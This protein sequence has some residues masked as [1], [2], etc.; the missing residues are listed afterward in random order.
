MLL[1][2]LPNCQG[3]KIYFSSDI[4]TSWLVD[5]LI[6]QLIIVFNSSFL[7][8]LYLIPYRIENDITVILAYVDAKPK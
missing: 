4:M 7:L 8:I 3:E 5:G 6:I 2:I 1:V